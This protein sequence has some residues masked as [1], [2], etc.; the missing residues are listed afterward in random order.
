MCS[1][2]LI[3][4]WRT[5]NNVRE[6]IVKSSD[7]Y[8]EV[9]K[10]RVDLNR[11]IEPHGDNT[12]NR[13]VDV[14]TLRGSGV[15]PLIFQDKILNEKL[16]ILWVGR[17][18][19]AMR[20]A[21]LKFRSYPIY[22]WTGKAIDKVEKASYKRVLG[23]RYYLIE[24]VKNAQCIGIVA[25][26]LG[27]S[28]NLE[29]I[30]RCKRIIENAGRKWYMLVVGKIT[31]TKLA[32]FA[33]MDAFV[34]VACPQNSLIDSNDF[35]KPILTPLELDA[36]IGDGDVYSNQYSADFTDLLKKFERNDLRQENG[37]NGSSKE[38]S[39]AL[40]PGMSVSIPGQGGAADFFRARQWQGL[41]YSGKEKGMPLQSLPTLAERGRSGVASGY[42][43][44]KR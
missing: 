20:N 29:I 3:Q 17:E 40:R 37:E 13:K 35:F 8:V 43:G 19:S 31:P 32:N 7:D 22:S 2:D 33:E 1:S 41:D 14:N 23:K 24:K 4:Y 27:V 39:I 26:T 42:R 30:E 6:A 10:L 12:N 36:A 38:R 28:G 11:V 21:A 15:G 16:A 44:E 18:S 34:L 5:M 25:G 9:A